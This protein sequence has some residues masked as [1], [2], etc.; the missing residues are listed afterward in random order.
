[1]LVEVVCSVHLR[2]VRTECQIRCDRGIVFVDDSY[3][4]KVLE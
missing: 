3:V 4:D 1:M 2:L